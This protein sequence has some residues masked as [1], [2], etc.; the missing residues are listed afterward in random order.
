MLQEWAYQHPMRDVDK[1][2]QRL[3]DRQS[4]IGQAID[5]WWFRL[6]AWAMASGV[7]LHLER[8]T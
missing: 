8:L 6:K 3:I 1:L 2:R 5:R 7:G 4:I